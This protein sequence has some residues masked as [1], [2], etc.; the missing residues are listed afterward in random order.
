MVLMAMAASMRVP[1]P[2]P[3]KKISVLEDPGKFMA[4][5]IISITFLESRI[6]EIILEVI[7]ILSGSVRWCV[8]LMAWLVDSLLHPEDTSLFKPL[9]TGQSIDLDNFQTRL[10]DSSNV[11]LHLLLSSAP[12]SFL[13]AICRRVSHL[14]Y[15]SR[16]AKSTTAQ[17]Q[18]GAPIS[19]PPPLTSSTLR[20][21]YESIAT[22]TSDSVIHF[23]AFETFLTSISASVKDAYTTA[24][25]ASSTLQTQLQQQPH[26][27]GGITRNAAEQTML[28]GGP[29]PAALVP[30]MRH[31]FTTL[32]PTL[33]SGID[34]AKLF[35]SDF[36][37]LALDPITPSSTHSPSPTAPE[38]TLASLLGPEEQ[39]GGKRA[40][41]L[42]RVA[43]TIDIFQRV[44]V[45]L[46]QGPVDGP[47]NENGVR[48]KAR[49]AKRWRRCARCTAVMEDYLTQRPGVQFMVI[50]Q[51]KCSCAG[52][53]NLLTGKQ[54]VI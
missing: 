17:S 14:D 48:E 13:T 6:A 45:T 31:I 43:H 16:K 49:D 53:W 25:L 42:Q 9:T 3:Q 7:R 37:L 34:P 32:L 38:Q 27:K 40:A 5:F 52:N 35:F 12:R 10:R 4:L 19:I 28:F 1:D 20:A 23:R 29:L 46:G 30:A 24:G 26:T 51:R 8:D 36:S 2:G 50:Q 47:V 41:D 22:I 54:I 18:A 39:K 21:A 33:R 11:A 44:P 15:V